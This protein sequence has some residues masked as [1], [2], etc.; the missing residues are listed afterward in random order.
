MDFTSFC[1]HFNW[2]NEHWFFNI[3]W[4]LF[5]VI[6]ID[7]TCLLFKVIEMCSVYTMYTC[8]NAKHVTT[9]QLVMEV[10]SYWF[11]WAI[12]CTNVHSVFSIHWRWNH[13]KIKEK[14]MERVKKNKKKKIKNI[15]NF[16]L[17]SVI[18]KLQICIWSGQ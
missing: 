9:L 4:S 14:I 11:Q 6:S 13:F 16:I 5:L 18:C 8:S 7:W 12:Q 15:V 10:V 17:Q 1:N 2:L 3:Q